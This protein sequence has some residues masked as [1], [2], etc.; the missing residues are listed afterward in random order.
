M[1]AKLKPSDYVYPPGSPLG[2]KRGAY[3][4]NT[5]ARARN[6]L[7]RAA[8]PQTKG[9]YPTVARKVRQRWGEAIASTSRSRG[10]VNTPGP[11]GKNTASG[12]SQMRRR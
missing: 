9:S 11:R 3:P 6:A 4:I 7:S 10:S 1:A 12:R 5:K 8:Q 2:G